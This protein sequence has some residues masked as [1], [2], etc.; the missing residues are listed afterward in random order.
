[1]RQLF[2]YCD[3]DHRHLAF[4]PRFIGNRLYADF[5]LRVM[6]AREQFKFT[7]PPTSTVQ[8]LLEKTI[9]YLQECRFYKRC[10]AMWS[11]VRALDVQQDRS[12]QIEL[13]DDPLRV[14]REIGN[15]GEV[16]QVGVLATQC[17]GFVIGLAKGVVAYLELDLVD[18]QFM[19]HTCLGRSRVR[20]RACLGPLS[21]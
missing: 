18:F 14:E 11:S 13:D 9:E 12:S 8:F 16:V 21:Q 7:A 6:G 20:Q 17:I 10:E 1:M 5:P 15:R 19:Q 2:A 3:V 4:L